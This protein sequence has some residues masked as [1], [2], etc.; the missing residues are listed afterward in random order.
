[1]K[2]NFQKTEK[3]NILLLIK[4]SKNVDILVTDAEISTPTIVA[5]SSP[6]DRTDPNKRAIP[7]NTKVTITALS[8]SP[9]FV[10]SVEQQY[11]RIDLD[12]QWN[13]LYNN[14]NVKYLKSELSEVTEENVKAYV[15][16]KIKYLEEGVELTV[17]VSGK[18]ATAT[19]TAKTDSLCYVGQ[20]VL[21]ITPAETRQD[22]ADVL[23]DTV[24][25]GLEYDTTVAL[26]DISIPSFIYGV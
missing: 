17:S 25:D 19:L 22:L 16:S 23:N 6:F 10:G 12:R 24:L 20:L 5:D 8:S 9:T 2:I 4:E 11:R 15:K 18:N 3:E 7:A 1:M 13:V 21:N 26:P 14:T